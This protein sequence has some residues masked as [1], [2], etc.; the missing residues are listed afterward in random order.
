LLV[1]S[2]GEIKL[3][4]F[5]VA[6]Q[7]DENEDGFISETHGTYH[8]FAPEMC[9]G[10]KY[11]GY[12]ADIWAVGITLYILATG[13]VPFFSEENNP[14]ELFE[15]ISTANITFPEPAGTGL[16]SE[17]KDLIRS[18]LVSDT[19]LRYSLDQILSHPFVT[20]ENY[21]LKRR[22][23]VKSFMTHSKENRSKR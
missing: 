3:G 10:A 4:D 14:N 2:N 18:I 13:R 21:S 17:L 11:S 22:P 7:F 6:R 15:K 19:D 5:G 9:T 12:K 1:T 8:F 16:S 20:T 23:D